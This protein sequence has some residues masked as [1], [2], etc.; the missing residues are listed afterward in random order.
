MPK[1]YCHYC[2]IYLTH[3]SPGGRRQHNAGRKHIHNK[4][5]YW[6]QL[7]SSGAVHPPPYDTHL[8]GA[9]GS[10]PQKGLGTYARG[11]APGAA[12]MGLPMVKP[13]E[14]VKVLRPPAGGG[15]PGGMGGGMRPAPGLLDPPPMGG[16][17]GPHMGGPG[18]MIMGPMGGGGMRPMGGPQGPG[19]WR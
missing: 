5:D 11:V 2:C 16:G 7:L 9:I 19:G 17:G 12:S 4:I 10:D 3:S 18:P 13:G 6:M 14:H 1:F 15:G 8:A